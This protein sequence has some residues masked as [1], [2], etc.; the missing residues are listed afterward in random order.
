MK[1]KRIAA[2]FLCLVLLLAGGEVILS[3]FA[4]R[5]NAADTYSSPLQDLGQTENFNAADYPENPTDYSLQVIALAESTDGELYVYVYQPSKSKVTVD[6]IFLSTAYRTKK[7][8]KEYDLFLV[9][10][11][12]VFYKYRVV[13]IEILAAN[14]RYYEISDIHRKWDAA[15]DEAPGAGNTAST[16]TYPVGKQ[17][18]L[19]TDSTGKVATAVH[20]IEYVQILNK[21][22]G[23]AR[24]E[25]KTFNWFMQHDDCDAHFVAFSTDKKIDK[26]LEAD[27][28][29]VEQRYSLKTFYGSINETYGEKEEKYVYID[30]L[31]KG[32]T[33]IGDGYKK[34]EAV[35]GRI[36][37]TSDFL[38]QDFDVGLFA[39][40]GF[41]GKSG[42][43]FTEEA[44]DAL[45]K[46]EWV[47]SF[48]ET[49]NTM[50]TG[51]ESFSKSYSI[52]G[53]VKIMRLKFETDGV[54]YDLGVVDNKQSGSLEPSM[55]V[56]GDDLLTMI[57]SL[58][59]LVVLLI[60]VWPFV[61]PLFILFLQFIGTG[62]KFLL[63]YF[64]KF[65]WWLLGLPFRLL[66]SLLGGRK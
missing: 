27:L 4:L 22:V 17:Y 10:S 24:Y 29:Y 60:L 53:D 43:A 32:Y 33:A 62:A 31:Q 1:V 25:N 11:S 14:V 65:L 13:D 44:Y 63:S 35:W 49:P 52:V 54:I 30:Y 57:L 41:D 19:T 42:T 23:F 39:F 51:Y 61:S 34:S 21:F 46:T 55:T 38:A 2:L 28:Y 3:A 37:K 5:A 66:S 59:V 8:F 7:D 18:T 15:Y 36:Q 64:V 56:R 58:L 50:K 48:V 12:G 9:A 47:M 26:L 16:V 20:D 6:S 40:S 45:S